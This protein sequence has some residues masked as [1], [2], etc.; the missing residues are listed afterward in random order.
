LRR[1][2]SSGVNR[3]GSQNAF[4]YG[5]AFFN[6]QQPHIIASTPL[7]LTLP[8]ASK[9]SRKA[10][11]DALTGGVPTFDSSVSKTSCILSFVPTQNLIKF[12]HH[13]MA[14]PQASKQQTTIKH[15]ID[16]TG[17]SIIPRKV[18]GLRPKM[19]I[20]PP[21]TQRRH[22]QRARTAGA[23]SLLQNQTQNCANI[24]LLF[25]PLK[26]RF[27]KMTSSARWTKLRDFALSLSPSTNSFHCAFST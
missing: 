5:D 11:V 27:P 9:S 6:Q 18:Q 22:E 23:M 20:E 7:F 13:V 3:R 15:K 10:D 21:C 24:M 17:L 2:T 19:P 16:R 4:A 26:R 25:Y 8:S 14:T 1:C 12:G